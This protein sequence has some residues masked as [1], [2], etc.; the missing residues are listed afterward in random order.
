MKLRSHLQTKS[1]QTFTSPEVQ[2]QPRPATA[3]APAASVQS[4]EYLDLQTQLTVANRF[5]HSFQNIA[6]K[7]N[8]GT[9]Y[10]PLVQPKLAIGAAGDRY[11]QEADR[12]AA[13]VVQRLNTPQLQQN[14]YQVQRN[15]YSPQQQILTPIV[16]CSKETDQLRSF[17]SRYLEVI[18]Q[19]RQGKSISIE[20]TH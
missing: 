3:P 13:Q 10:L 15:L 18:D 8:S 19:L 7:T 4:A 2:F 16:Q 11:E 5:G 17:S 1:S 20:L 9:A 14:G 6:P 12:V